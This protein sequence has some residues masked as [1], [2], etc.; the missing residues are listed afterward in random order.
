MSEVA[1][2]Q[3]VERSALMD[4]TPQNLEEAKELAT[5]MSESQLVPKDYIKSPHNILVAMMM[6]SE[7][8]LKPMQ[9]LQNIA[10]INGR[11]SVWGDAALAIVRSHPLCEYVSEQVDGQGDG[12]I[13]TCEVKRRGQPP[14]VQT[15]SV[16]DAIAAGLWGKQGPWKQ[17]PRRMLQ[18]RARGFAIRDAFP[19]ALRGMY[20]AEEAADI[21]EREVAGEHTFQSEQQ[22]VAAEDQLKA[23][24]R[25]DSSTQGSTDAEATEPVEAETAD[26]P[27]VEEAGSGVFTEL[28]EELIAAG[29]KDEVRAV[30]AKQREAELTQEERAYLAEQSNNKIEEMKN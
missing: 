18:M 21:P 29:S 3:P 17:Y 22:P 1:T 28:M 26:S 25:G 30:M 4:I 12:M 16:Q 27:P 6:G 23:A 2:L 13:A 9:A 15:F 7:V 24:L 11:P 5:L 20:I 8:G 10:V 14:T 19:D